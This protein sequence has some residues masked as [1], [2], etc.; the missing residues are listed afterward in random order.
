MK[1][2]VVREIAIYLFLLIFLAIWMHYKAWID[3]PLEH[4]KALPTSPFGMLHPLIFTFFVYIIILIVRVF[5]HLVR[6]FSAKRRF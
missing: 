6:R 1:K 4:L 3:H 5:I 2:L